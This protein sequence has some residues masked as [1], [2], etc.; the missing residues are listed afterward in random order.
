MIFRPLAALDI[1][2]RAIPPDDRTFLVSH[3]HRV[4][5]EPAVDAVEPSEA[6]F[7]FTWLS[8]SEAG[9]PGVHELAEIVGMNGNLS[10]PAEC[11]FLRET[12]IVEPPL[13]EKIGRTIQ[14]TC[15]RQCGNGSDYMPEL[16][17]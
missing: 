5:E 1:G 6:C 15:P 4:K 17:C 12:R 2:I 7:L 8:G 9:K 3:R 10:P 13:V 16:I 11:L 14:P